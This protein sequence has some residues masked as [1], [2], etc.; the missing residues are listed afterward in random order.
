MRLSWPAVQTIAGISTFASSHQ[1]VQSLTGGKRKMPEGGGAPASLAVLA[2]GGEIGCH[3]GVQRRLVGCPFVKVA[4]KYQIATGIEVVPQ[5]NFILRAVTPIVKR[6]MPEVIHRRRQV[7]GPHLSAGKCSATP[8]V[9]VIGHRTGEFGCV[10]VDTE[11]AEHTVGKDRIA[12][13]EDRTVVKAD[14]AEERSPRRP[15]VAWNG[16]RQLTRPP[17]GE[18]VGCL[19]CLRDEAGVFSHMVALKKAV[20][21]WQVHHALK[22]LYDVIALETLGHAQTKS[23]RQK[24]G[25]RQA[26]R[27]RCSSPA[28][29]LP[30]R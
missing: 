21:W 2:S 25:R 15:S 16:K 20:P 14:V 4:L 24:A 30:R 22:E 18:P 27:T 17:P 9:H 29:W 13:S 3:L 1:R 10:M 8:L 5:K 26:M 7:S 11:G 6:P 19:H 12:V 28:T 23:G